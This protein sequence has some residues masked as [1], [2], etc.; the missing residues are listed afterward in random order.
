M[1]QLLALALLPALVVAQAPGQGTWVHERMEC[2]QAQCTEAAGC[3]WSAALD[4]P[5]GSGTHSPE[6][7]MGICTGSGVDTVPW[8]PD[9]FLDLALARPAIRVPYLG[10]MTRRAS[11][12]SSGVLAGARDLLYKMELRACIPVTNASEE[13]RVSISDA[14]DILAANRRAEQL[15]AAMLR[16]GFVDYVRDNGALIYDDGDVR[17]NRPD[18]QAC[19]ESIINLACARSFPMQKFDEETGTHLVVR[20]ICGHVC[21]NILNTCHPDLRV[22]SVLPLE[23]GLELFLPNG[24]DRLLTTDGQCSAFTAEA[25]PRFEPDQEESQRP[26][27]YE[28]TGGTMRWHDPVDW[29][30]ANLSFPEVPDDPRERHLYRIP[31]PPL[32]PAPPTGSTPAGGAA[33]AARA[34]ALL[35]VL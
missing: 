32:P 14:A 30:T 7:N 2:G 33:T 13:F 34:C 22:P 16:P 35:L 15:V 24:T 21:Q 6:L 9:A 10:I 27:V 18:L 19:L 12:S 20:D 4:L 25:L 11:A 29:A 31:V 23:A 1:L 3:T 8:Q 28:C 17:L 26:W 5:N